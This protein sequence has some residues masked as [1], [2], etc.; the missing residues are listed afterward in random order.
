VTYWFEKARAQIEARRAGRA[1]LI[2][3]QGIRGGA[4]RRVLERLK[5][6]GEIFWAYSDR[7]LGFVIN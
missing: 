2:A 5:Q 3:T 6:S 7:P 4:N 1:G